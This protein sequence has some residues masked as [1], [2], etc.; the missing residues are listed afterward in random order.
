MSGDGYTPNDEHGILR[1]L[2]AI[3]DGVSGLTDDPYRSLAAFV[4][5][6]GGYVR[7]PEPFAQFQWRSVE[8]VYRC[9]RMNSSSMRQ[10]TRAFSLHGIPTRGRFRESRCVRGA[11]LRLSGLEASVESSAFRQAKRTPTT[12]T[13]SL[14]CLPTT[15]CRHRAASSCKAPP[16]V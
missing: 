7:T 14:L 12:L 6:A 8:R 3:P 15:P 11:R 9:G 1:A 5:D 16:P 2:S 10:S 13:R 4:R